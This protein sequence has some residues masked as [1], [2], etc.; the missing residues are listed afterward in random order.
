M[1]AEYA[2]IGLGTMGSMAAWQLSKRNKSVIGFE[3]FGRGHDRSAAGGESRLFRTAYMEGPEYVPLLMDSKKLWRELE[4]ES[5]NTLLE[6]IGGLTI[7][8]PDNPLLKNVLKSTENYNLDHEVISNQSAKSRFPQHKLLD[9]EIIILDKESGFL[10]P[11]LSVVSAINRAEELGAEIKTYEKIMNI[12]HTSDGV[13]INSDKGQYKVQKVLLSGGSYVGELLPKY[14]A[15]IDPSKI[16]MSWFVPKSIEKFNKSKYP[17]FIRE[18]NGDKFFGTPTFDGSMV[19]VGLGD[20]YNGGENPNKLS[21]YVSVDELSTIRNIVSKYFND[22]YSDP[23]RVSVH[24]DAYT[25][26]N[27]AMVGP[28][29]DSEN[30]IVMTGFSG[31]GFK[32]APVMGKIASDLMIDGKTSYDISFLSPDR[33]M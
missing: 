1:D 12:E 25:P 6:M 23:V 31:H 16:V 24:M 30:I 10:R 21:N 15:N 13:I 2:V 18:S 5:N 11:E 28:V 3:Q 33:F 14:N 22:L 27:N 26:D 8:N 29:A 9:D 4:S 20:P 32:M 7:G 17:I 19:K